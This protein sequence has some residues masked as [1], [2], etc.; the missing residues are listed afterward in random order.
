MTGAERTIA[1]PEAPPGQ[2]R[3]LVPLTYVTACW[4]LL[5][6]IYRGYYALGGTWGQPGVP[7][8]GHLGELRLVNGVGAAVVL[9]AAAVPVVLLPLWR[10][11]AARRWLLAL[12]WIVAVGCCMHAIIDIVQRVLSLD[13]QLA[14]A[15]PDLW[16]SVDR[17]AADLQ[18]LYGNEPW[19]LIEGLLFGALAWCNLAGRAR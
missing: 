2:A 15:Y 17:R 19:F 6:A 18:D 5:Y 16:Q 12:C 7:A 9:I 4:A 10:R 13:G 8:P 1:A 14:I 3:A 11:P